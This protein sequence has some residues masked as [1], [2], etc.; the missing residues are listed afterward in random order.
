[1]CI[2]QHQTVYSATQG[3]DS[4]GPQVLAQPW[5]A[6][7][8]NAVYRRFGETHFT[9]TEFIVSIRGT[10]WLRLTLF[11]LIWRTVYVCLTTCKYC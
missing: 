2:V 7:F 6:F 5:F 8:E 4:L 9:H 11:R 3:E 1:M 10:P